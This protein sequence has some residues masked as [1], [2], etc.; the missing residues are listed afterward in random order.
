MSDEISVPRM[1][2]VALL[3]KLKHAKTL[4]S[5]VEEGR[6]STKLIHEALSTI[7]AECHDG[8]EF[9]CKIKD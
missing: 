3:Y 9:H 7:M 1:E 2:L 4:L 6:T 5:I 8:I